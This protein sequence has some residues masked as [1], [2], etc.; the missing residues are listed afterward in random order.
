MLYRGLVCEDGNATIRRRPSGKPLRIGEGEALRILDLGAAV[1]DEPNAAPTLQPQ[2]DPVCAVLS[3]TGCV[4][5]DALCQITIGGKNDLPECIHGG[6]QTWIE[7]LSEF[8][9]RHDISHLT[10]RPGASWPGP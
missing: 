9:Q 4:P 1:Q 3:K 2:R 7:A 8:V 10:I 5:L 6:K